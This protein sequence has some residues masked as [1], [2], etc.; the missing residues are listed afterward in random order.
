MEET[1]IDG[2]A[3]G[4]TLFCRNTKGDC[5]VQ[6]TNS[7]VRLIACDTLAMVDEWRPKETGHTITVAT[8]NASQLVIAATG[9]TLYYFEIG[10]RKIIE[11]ATATLEHEVACLNIAPFSSG[12]QGGGGI[13][14]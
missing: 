11:T 13:L 4:R 6:V 10:Q 8:A 5:L 12:S 2:F 9:N 3:P 7:S 14:C 1:T